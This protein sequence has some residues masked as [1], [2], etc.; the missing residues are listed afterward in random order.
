MY[1]EESAIVDRSTGLCQRCMSNCLNTKK[2]RCLLPIALL[3]PATIAPQ[4]IAI[5]GYIYFPLISGVSGFIIFWNFPF[6]VYMTASRPLYYED[7][8][9]DE[10]KLP[11][12]N[13][14][15]RIR[16]KFQTILIWILIFT[17]SIL[18]S[19]LS[20]YWLYKTENRGDLLQVIGITG[21]IIKIFQIINNTIGRV[22]LKIIKKKIYTENTKYNIKERESITDIVK[23]KQETVDISGIELT[24]RNQNIIISIT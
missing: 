13:I 14:Q 19:A 18:V 12:H 6:L 7:L 9:I 16:Y 4:F 22:M 23:L 15:P 17:N 10:S 8:F 20:D 1:S 24:E 11:N 21:G 5:F 2:K 3:F